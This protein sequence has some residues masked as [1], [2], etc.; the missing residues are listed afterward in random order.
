[1][2]NRIKEQQ[3]D[4]FADRTSCSDWWA[5][6]FRLLLSGCAYVLTSVIRRL[7]LKGTVLAKAQ[8]GTIRLKL[9]K[10]GAV[11]IKNTRRIKFLLSSSYPYQ[12]LFRKIHYKLCPE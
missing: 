11:I 8:C 7:F 2:E 12:D 4:L 10:I 5:N 9:L 3:L 1:M 6:N